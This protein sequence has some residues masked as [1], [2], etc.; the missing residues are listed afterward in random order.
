MASRFSTYLHPLAGRPL[1]WHIL[2]ALAHAEP[3]PASLML[4]G[5][6]ELSS[7]PFADLPVRPEIE[8]SEGEASFEMLLE[9]VPEGGLVLVDAAAVLAAPLPA[10]MLEGET[11]RLWTTASGEPIL[12]WVPA[13]QRE[14]LAG[15]AALA[16]IGEWPD[17]EISVAP[18]DWLAVRDRATLARATEH[19]RDRVVRRLMD[20]GVT[21][22]LPDT[23]LVDVDVR[24]GRD[25]VL[26]PGVV[27][28][29]Q[30]SIGDETV[31]GPGCRIVDSWIG[32]GVE[33]KGWN[34][35]AH[36]SVRNR[37]VLEPYV[38]RG[39]D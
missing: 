7:E 1:C 33:M 17:A 6:A 24:V 13:A 12:A 15:A 28:E 20:Q 31:I 2:S 11:V 25:T 32:S 21:I 34:F 8:Y 23:V 9:R 18:P 36:T 37:A 39:F 19:V 38:R 22:M 16:R 10:S 5:G 35:V 3:A 29:G 4:F 27:L 30:T 14:R 26:Y